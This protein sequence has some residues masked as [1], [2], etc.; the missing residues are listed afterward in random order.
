M[1]FPSTYEYRRQR[2]EL[3]RDTNFGGSNTDMAAALKKPATHIS[4]YISGRTKIGPKVA[5]EIE[6]AFNLK[7]NELDQP[8]D[9]GVTYEALLKIKAIIDKIPETV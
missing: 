8:I 7:T 5:R 4:A 1:G 2:L 9:N 6:V 3:L